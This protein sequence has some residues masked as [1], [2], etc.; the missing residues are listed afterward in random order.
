MVA[1]SKIQD[2]PKKAIDNIEYTVDIK[3]LN[4]KTSEMGMGTF[5]K[6]KKENSDVGVI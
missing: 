3:S 6:T 5:L 1:E 4:Q 2:N